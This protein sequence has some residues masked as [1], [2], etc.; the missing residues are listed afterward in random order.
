VAATKSWPGEQSA[1]ERLAQ[2]LGSP[3]DEMVAEVRK[4]RG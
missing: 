4:R 1:V 2:A 3:V